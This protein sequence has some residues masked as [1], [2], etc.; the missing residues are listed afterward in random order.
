LCVND[1]DINES[2][3]RSLGGRI[4]YIPLER[5]WFY[6]GSIFKGD[7]FHE[8]HIFGMY[9]LASYKPS[10]SGYC[11]PYMGVKITSP[12]IVYVLQDSFI[13]L[14]G[15]G[16]KNESQVS[17]IRLKMVLTKAILRL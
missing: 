1:I 13:A 7:K 11:F 17:F 14:E 12:H 15:G 3:C 2:Q 16:E 5:A 10:D 6:T 8:L 9:C 4:D